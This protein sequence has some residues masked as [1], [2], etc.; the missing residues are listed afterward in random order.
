MDGIFQVPSIFRLSSPPVAAKQEK[1][2][3]AA[4][5]A[6]NFRVCHGFKNAAASP[7]T[8]LRLNIPHKYADSVTGSVEFAPPLR[9]WAAI[10]RSL[11]GVPGVYP[12]LVLD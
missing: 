6:P 11:T 4:I 9:D 1:A 10:S 3:H 5:N 7:P 12:G 8:N 2:L